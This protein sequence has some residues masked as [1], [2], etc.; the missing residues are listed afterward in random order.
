[1]N[2]MRT[3]FVHLQRPL[4]QQLDALHARGLNRHNLVI[5][6][7]QHQNRHINLLQILRKV[8]LRKVLDGVIHALVARRHTLG[9][10]ASNLALALLHTRSVEAKEG[11][12][13]NIQEELRSVLVYGCAEGVK[14]GHIS[15][16]CIGGRLEHEGRHRADEDGLLEAFGAVLA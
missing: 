6:A 7:V 8:R 14:H 3:P 10:P 13:G 5:V 1:M 16:F 15:A 2:G 9:P 12:G 11:P 4:G